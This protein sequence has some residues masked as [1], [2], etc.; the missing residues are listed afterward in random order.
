[1]EV[2]I[3]RGNKAWWTMIMPGLVIMVLLFIIPMAILIRYSFYEHIP[4]QFMQPAWIIDS[5][6]TFLTNSHY[7]GVLIDSIILG[8]KVVFFC[9]LLGYPVA[10]ALARKKIPFHRI[11]SSIVIIPL[12]TSPVVT[13]FGWV[14]IVADS[15]LL[16][17]FLITSGLIDTPLKLMFNETGVMIALIQSSLP[18]MILSIRANLGSLDFSLEEAAESLGA[19][20]FHTF[21]KVT[22]PLSLPGI[23]AGSLIVFIS[24]ISAFVTPILL[25]GGRVQTLAS[26]IYNETLVTLNWPIA[27]AASIIM[28]IITVLLLWGY[29]KLMESKVL[30]GGR[31]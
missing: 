13:A 4:G 11:A 27:A 15:G 10:Y 22:L 1:M 2:L 8:I 26:L 19:N 25:G 16:N 6:K 14:V 5:Y 31:A 24:T 12:L 28:L 17:R 23:F 3:V 18:F 21:I 30:G 7:R 9:I 29:S 20:R